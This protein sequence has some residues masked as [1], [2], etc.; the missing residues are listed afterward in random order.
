VAAPGWRDRRR[1]MLLAVAVVLVMASEGGAQ[2]PAEEAIVPLAEYRSAASRTLAQ[3]YLSDLRLLY[4]SVRR[5]APEVDFHRYGLGFRRPFG[6]ETVQPHL[7][8]WVWLPGEPGPDGTDIG[9]RAADAFRRYAPKLLPHLV[10]RSQIRADSR[11]GG[12]GL[13]LTW[14]KQPAADPPIGET[15]VVFAPKSVVE[16]FVSGTI[17]MSELLA[18]A[19]IRTF[20]GQTEIM[21]PRFSISDQGPSAPSPSC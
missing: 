5:C 13:V 15:L 12:Y 14:I 10:A 4:E 1:R 9:T 20:D 19:R 2:R 11:V 8:M 7:A 18:Q 21:V 16:P 3:A 17:R 6:M